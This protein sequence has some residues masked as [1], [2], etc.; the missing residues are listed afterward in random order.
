MSTIPVARDFMV[1]TL[2]TMRPEMNIFDAIA[3]LLRNRISGAP[4]VDEQN[5]V[6]GVLS[7]KDCLRVFVSGAIHQLAGGIVAD[8]MSKGAVTI[9]PDDDLFKVADIFLKNSFRRLPVVEKGVLMGQVSRRDVL[10]VSKKLFIDPDARK[11]WSDSKYLTDEMKA[12]L[13]GP[14]PDTPTQ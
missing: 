3:I 10:F 12:K 14:T 13:E 2:Q 7:E 6:V 11:T 1:K 4:V 8:Y 5:H 9:E